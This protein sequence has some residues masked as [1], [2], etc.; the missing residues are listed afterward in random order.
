MLLGLGGNLDHPP[1]AF[2]EA[3]ARLS[4]RHRVLAVSSL[5]RSQAHG[6]AQPE[7]FNRA[8]LLRVEIHPAGLLDEC[9]LL[10]AAAGRDRTTEA[11]WGPRPLDIDLLLVRGVIHR[12]PRLQLPHPRFAERA[13]ALV[14]AAEV[15]PDWIHP[16]VGMSIAGLADAALVSNPDAVW[17]I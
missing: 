15:V 5:Y 12:G 2:E 10:E 17:A 6:P 14:P 11:R 9:H 16:L 8:V 4:K 13:F 1:S 7:Y 3:C